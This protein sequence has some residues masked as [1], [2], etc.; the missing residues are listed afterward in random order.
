MIK[1]KE[2]IVEDKETFDYLIGKLLKTAKTIN[3]HKSYG[4]HSRTDRAFELATRYDNILEKIRHKYRQEWYLYCDKRG[5]A[6]NHD[7]GDMYA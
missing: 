2:F 6:H 3:T 5:W 1:F 4:G 7:G